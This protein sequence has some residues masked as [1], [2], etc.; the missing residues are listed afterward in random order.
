M[1]YLDKKKTAEEM[2]QHFQNTSSVDYSI[3]EGETLVLQMKNKPEGS[4]KSKIFEQGLNNLSMEGNSDGKESFLSIS[5]PPPPPAPLSPATSV[6][7]SPSN[8]PPKITLDGNSTEKSPNLTKDEAEHQHF[9]DNESSQ[10]TQDDDF[11]DFQAA[12]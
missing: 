1:N 12:G 11:G 7:N 10:D 2:E 5:L 4:V 8:L 3:K 9:P 6:K